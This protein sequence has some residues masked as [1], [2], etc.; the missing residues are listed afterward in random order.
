MPQLRPSAAKTTKKMFITFLELYW[1]HYACKRE[2][3]SW[4]LTVYLSSRFSVALEEVEIC[5]E[6]FV[7]QAR[8]AVG[9]ESE[10]NKFALVRESEKQTEAWSWGSWPL[11]QVWKRG[12]PEGGFVPRW[13][14]KL[15]SVYHLSHLPQK[16]TVKGPLLLMQS[17]AEYI[18]D[19]HQNAE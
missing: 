13:N 6:S 3:I 14:A 9:R 8:E 15:C 2:K 16:Q 19:C 5:G 17:R 7:S 1:E 12:N 18:S 10:M 4:N 11:R